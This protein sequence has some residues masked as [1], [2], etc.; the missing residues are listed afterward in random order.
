MRTGEGR[1][2]PCLRWKQGEYQALLRLSA[3]ARAGI[4]PLIEVPEIGFDFETKT[5]AKSVDEHLQPFAGRVREKWGREECF[6]DVRNVGATER[7]ATG[8]DV[9]TFVFDGLRARG[10]TAVPV[11]GPAEGNETQDAVR[12]IVANE[13]VKGTI[14]QTNAL[15]DRA[16]AAAKARS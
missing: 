12:D 6:V 10:V 16:E 11:V 1:Y 2:I 5:E 13:V 14:G 4:V 7:L 15:Q 3:G 9:V 8:Q